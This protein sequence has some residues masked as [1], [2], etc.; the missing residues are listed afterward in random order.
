MKKL[1]KNRRHR[2]FFSIRLPEGVVA[3]TISVMEEIAEGERV[4]RVS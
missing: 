3:R 4:E 2:K 1:G